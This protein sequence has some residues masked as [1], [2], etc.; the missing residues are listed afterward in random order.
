MFTELMCIEALHKR[1]SNLETVLD[2]LIKKVKPIPSSPATTWQDRLVREYNE[3]SSKLSSLEAFIEAVNK[4]ELEYV[5]KSKFGNLYKQRQIMRDYKS[6]LY[7]RIK[8]EGI[9]L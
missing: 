8:D 2:D 1:V 6:I 3:L 4:K 5:G 9:K 7:K